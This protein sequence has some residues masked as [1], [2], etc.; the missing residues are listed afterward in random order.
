EGWGSFRGALRRHLGKWGAGRL[1][2][3]SRA[4]RAPGNDMPRL[5][6]RKE[7]EEFFARLARVSPAPKTELEYDNVFE[8]LVAV[9]LSAQATD[10]S[11]NKATE[12]LYKVANTPKKMVALGEKRLA[13]YIKTI[14]LYRGK[15]K[16]V[17]ALSK[18]LIEK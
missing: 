12:E 7:I 18:L 10:K 11:V 9:V 15:A 3:A 2:I 4:P 17:V 5:L 8:L 16:N 13:S 14:G 1:C 6:N